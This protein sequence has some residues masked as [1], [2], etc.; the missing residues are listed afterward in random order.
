MLGIILWLT[1][2]AFIVGVFVWSTSILFQQ[3][4][5]WKDYAKKAGL[6]YKPGKTME[7]PNLGG[8]MKGRKVGLFSAPQAIPGR[9]GERFVTVIE[10]EM[11][12]GMP[13]AA[14]IATKEYADMVAPLKLPAV[15]EP[16]SKDWDKTYIVKTRDGKVLKA[17]LTPERCKVLHG[18]FSMRNSIAL[19]FFDEE[20][21]ILRIETPDPLR[22]AAHLE[23]I[24]K[25]V[26][27]VADR[28]E[29]TPEERGEPRPEAT[30]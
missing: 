7:S 28:L 3:K 9:R 24:M 30:P 11:G 20:D 19:F 16:E 13:T 21:S 8:L 5:A 2:S 22:D 15:V 14:A 27:A 18:V 6:N 10:V 17:Y 25:R 1:L 4:K 26:M 23:K 29:L 12:P